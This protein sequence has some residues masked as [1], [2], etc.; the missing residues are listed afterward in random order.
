MTSD[1]G[2]AILL[3]S[4]PAL[5]DAGR[6]AASARL[7][8]GLTLTR[9]PEEDPDLLSFSTGSAPALQVRLVSAPYA[10]AARML[11]GL[12]S[13]PPGQAEAAPAHLEI[14]V[15]GLPRDPRRHDALLS[16]LVC[17]VLKASDAPAAAMLGHGV[18]FHRPG[19]FLRSVQ[20]EQPGA[21]PLGVC[22]DLSIAQEADTGLVSFLTHG[23]PRYSRED[24]YITA[25]RAMAP[26][27]L[28]L[29]ALMVRTLFAAPPGALPA[30]DGAGPALTR[31]PSPIDAEATVVRMDLAEEQA[32]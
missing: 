10:V 15:T 16:R 8:T 1:T 13:P 2:T 3:L 7:L 32:P 26:A 31:Q 24:I 19:V 9:K 20:G 6:L 29:A 11:R 12:T 18:M 22:V 4:R 23:M 21:T 25:P 28:E 30:Q 17:A 5:P 27:A 14:S